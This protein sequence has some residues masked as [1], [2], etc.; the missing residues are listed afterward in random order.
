[1]AIRVVEK[2]RSQ[3]GRRFLIHWHA[4]D[5]AGEVVEHGASGFSTDPTPQEWKDRQALIAKAAGDRQAEYA[6]ETTY[7][8]QKE[9]YLVSQ[10][11]KDDEALVRKC[12]EKN[13]DTNIV[14][15]IH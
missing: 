10:G 5:D 7:Q 4:L 3:T 12:V 11:V 15:V 13:L 14:G 8:A 9:A 2:R 1:M 6:D